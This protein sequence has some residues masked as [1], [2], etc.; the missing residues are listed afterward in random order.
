MNKILTKSIFTRKRKKRTYKYILSEVGNPLHLFQW[1]KNKPHDTLKNYLHGHPRCHKYSFE[2]MQQIG[3]QSL[4][5]CLWTFLGPNSSLT[6][7]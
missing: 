4:F 5:D 2:M 1:Q 3:V 7:S 6:P